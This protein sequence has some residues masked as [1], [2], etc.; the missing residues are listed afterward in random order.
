[1]RGIV[2]NDP[3]STAANR[4]YAVSQYRQGMRV[5]IVGYGRVGIRTARILAEEGHH[6]TVVDNDRQKVRRAEDD[7]Y[8]AI[9]G[10]GSDPDTLEAAN[11]AD[12]EVVAAL[13][14]SV[15]V[16]HLAC[17]HAK[18]YGL[19]TVL[20]VD[21]DYPPAEYERYAEVADAIVYP[22]QLGAAGAKTAL[23]GGDV[24]VLAELAAD[25]QLT[26][27]TVHP[28]APAVGESIGRLELPAGS[29]LYAHGRG[30]ESLTIP[31]PSTVLEA[32]D[33]VALLVDEAATEATWEYL[34]GTPA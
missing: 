32:H 6:V 5:V 18:E 16:N 1:M 30:D 19:R 14:G 8:V 31:L 15:E 26:V 23:L 10:D 20:R 9:E 34:R 33:R 24:S 29:R 22:E 13:T 3:A 27:I 28:D 21:A 7:G 25:L 11:V 2:I 17:L 12:A 4:F